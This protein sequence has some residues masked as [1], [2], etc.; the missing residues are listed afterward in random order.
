MLKYLQTN[1]FP[2]FLLLLARCS[3]DGFV[4]LPE[5]DE[6]AEEVAEF[7][8]IPDNNEAAE[9]LAEFEDIPKYDEAAE[10]LAPHVGDCE[11]GVSGVSVGGDYSNRII[12]GHE[13]TPHKFP[14][15]VRIIRGC[16][17]GEWII[18]KIVCM[19]VFQDIIL[20]MVII[21]VIG[22]HCAGTYCHSP[23]QPNTTQV[24]VTM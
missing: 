11:C 16:A 15:I 2:Y 18:V 19:L 7:E 24:G 21:S 9:E 10:E 4:G 22:G 23:T 12:G 17:K 3:S 5:Y 1:I 13:A 20:G 6:A 14:W 8:G